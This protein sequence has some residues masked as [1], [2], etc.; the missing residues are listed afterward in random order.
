MITRLVHMKNMDRHDVTRLVGDMFLSHEQ[1]I[2]RLE[3]KV[4]TLTETVL[5][6]EEEIRILKGEAQ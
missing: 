4:E 2:E 3:Y 5:Q 1:E 6:L